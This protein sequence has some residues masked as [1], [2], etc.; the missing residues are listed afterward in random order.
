M[1]QYPGLKGGCTL[2][3]VKKESYLGLPGGLNPGK[4]EGEK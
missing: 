3:L 4:K 1:C 2:V